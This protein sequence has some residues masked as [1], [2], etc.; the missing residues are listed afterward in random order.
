MSP[1][2]SG[3]LLLSYFSTGIIMPV[4][5]LLLLSRGCTMQ[6]LP[7]MLGL[8]SLTALFLEVPS[9]VFADWRGRKPTCL[10][11]VALVMAAFML[12]LSAGSLPLVAAAMVLWGASRAF[13]SGSLDALIIDACLEEKGAER[14]APITAQLT[15]LRSAGIAL[16]ALVGGLLPAV[17][18][19]ALHLLLRLALLICEGLLCILFL[20]EPPREGTRSRLCDQLSASVALLRGNRPFWALALCMAVLAGS[21]GVVD[22]VLAARLPVHAPFQERRM[23]GIAVCGKLFAAHCG[24]ARLRTDLFLLGAPPLERLLFPSVSVGTGPPPSLASVLPSA[25][26]GRLSSLL[27]CAQ[28]QQHSGTDPSQR[29]QRQFKSGDGPEPCLSGLPTGELGPPC[30]QRCAGPPPGGQRPLGTLRPPSPACLRGLRTALPQR[31][32]VVLF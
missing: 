30:R 8:Y 12:L 25:F 10:L 28:R 14:L 21:Q 4:L 15:V 20:H 24:R 29:P 6:T 11:S 26:C 19:Y 13:S 3:I 27:H 2:H 9:G 16:G 17:R 22:V 1:L 7:L 31:Q 18:G 32:A 5:S 23:A